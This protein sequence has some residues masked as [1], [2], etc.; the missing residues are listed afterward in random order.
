[1]TL[2]RGAVEVRLLGQFCLAVDGR[3][4]DGLASGRLQA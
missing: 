2:A 1:M 4:V 3:P